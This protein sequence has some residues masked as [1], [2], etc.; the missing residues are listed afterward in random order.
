VRA[1]E[2][3]QT[4]LVSCPPDM[5]V[6]EAARLMSERGVGACLV[7]DGPRLAGVFTERDLL[8]LTA[9]GEDVRARPVAEAMTVQVTAAPPEADLLW[10]ADTMRRLHVRHLPV[11]TEDGMVVGI[12]SLRDLFAAAEAVLRLDPRGAEAAREVLA[13][14]NR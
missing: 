3:M 6:A 10:V 1:A 11:A 7:M 14:A 8:R 5:T 13:A 12:V 4:D 2:I 9:S